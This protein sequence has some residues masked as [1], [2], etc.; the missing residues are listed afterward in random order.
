MI[1]SAAQYLLDCIAVEQCE[2][3]CGCA[4]LFG[5]QRWQMVT[6]EAPKRLECDFELFVQNRLSLII[7]SE[8]VRQNLERE[9][10]VP[11]VTFQENIHKAGQNP[12]ELPH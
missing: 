11:K 10:A 9:I 4:R 12:F 2:T 1:H 5:S 3:A 8:R 7:A 6:N